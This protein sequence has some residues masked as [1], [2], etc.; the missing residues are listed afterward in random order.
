M[1]IIKFFLLCVVLSITACT[2]LEELPIPQPQVKNI[3]DVE[4]S[5][6]SNG[7]TINFTLPSDGLYTLTLIDKTT[8]DVIGRERFAGKKGENNKKI[9]TKSIIARY[10]YL[11]LEDENKIKINKTTVIIN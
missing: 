6:V 5:G 1:K 4:E 11:V 10:L 7:Q 3:F 8:G 9:Y 2:K